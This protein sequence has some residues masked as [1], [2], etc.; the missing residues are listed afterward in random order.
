MSTFIRN[1]L[2]NQYL[3]NKIDMY[4]MINQL[5]N[6]IDEI[7]IQSVIPYEKLIAL[8]NNN[9]FITEKN[10]SEKNDKKGG[11]EKSMVLVFYT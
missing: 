4:N 7:N 9:K 6:K 10:I 8:N 1:K 2:Q 11:V 5:Q 3:D